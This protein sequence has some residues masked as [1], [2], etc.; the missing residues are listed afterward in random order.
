[1]LTIARLFQAIEDYLPYLLALHNCIQIDEILLKQEPG[2]R[3]DLCSVSVATT[4]Q[5]GSAIVQSSHGG[6]RSLPTCSSHRRA[7][8]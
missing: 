8:R 2:E 7:L 6:R 1:M 3:V 4:D 5:P